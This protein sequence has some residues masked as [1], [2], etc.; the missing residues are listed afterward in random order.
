MTGEARSGPWLPRV[1]AVQP[2]AGDH[3]PGVPQRWLQ[4]YDRTEEARQ[5]D[6]LVADQDLVTR[7]G[8]QG[9]Q[10]PEYDVFATELAKYG[11]AVIR[12]WLFRRVIFAKCRERGFGGLPEPPADALRDRDTVEELACE[13]VA[14]ALV[15]FRDDVL[16][17]GRWVSSG[18]A[19]LK[20][21]FIGQC[22]I[23]FPNVY[24]RWLR[25]VP[26]EPAVD[27]HQVPALDESTVDG[28]ERQTLDRVEVRRLLGHI[29]DPRVKEALVLTRWA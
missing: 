27:P 5:L 24:R 1:Q 4:E 20:T 19:T 26:R 25:E 17:V 22:L 29:D 3:P 16:L 21:Y 10:G 23:R 6:R 12:G 18:G 13:T 11:L 8:L 14:V 9:F 15:H 2:Q 7:L 28:P